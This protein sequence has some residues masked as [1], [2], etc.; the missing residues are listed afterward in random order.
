M[1]DDG[2]FIEKDALN[3]NE[4]LEKIGIRR[5]KKDQGTFIES[6]PL[7]I[8]SFLK[9]I[10]IQKLTPKEISLDALKDKLKGDPQNAVQ[11]FKNA[12]GD[13]GY[14]KL[15]DQLKQNPSLEP[16]IHERAIQAEAEL[17]DIASTREI[18]VGNNR[19]K[20][21][22]FDERILWEI[23]DFIAHIIILSP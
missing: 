11:L 5:L 6:D 10:G 21:D 2:P 12:F 15:V 19:D 17:Q 20:S 9:S 14:Q 23:L 4:F 8:N 1:M 16:V 7:G 22:E 18:S 13:T 3:L